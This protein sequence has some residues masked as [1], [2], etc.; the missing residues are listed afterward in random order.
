[1]VMDPILEIG[2][3][4]KI[5]VKPVNNLT[6]V[7]NICKIMD[8]YKPSNAPHEKL[9][10]FIEDRKGHDWRY[11]ID[12]SKIQAELDWVPSEDFNNIIMRT[13]KFYLSK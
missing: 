12:N 7:K 9:I 5:I 2:C 3:M 6:L 11:A 1:M 8:K 10:S 13:I 4:Q